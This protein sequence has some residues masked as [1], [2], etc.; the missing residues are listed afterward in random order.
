MKQ[1]VLFRVVMRR[2][3]VLKICLNHALTPDIVYSPKDDKTWLFAANDFSEGEISLQKFCLRFKTK[4][5][6]TEFKDAVD[7]AR[8]GT[9]E[10]PAKA[11]SGAFK[12]ASGDDVIFVDEIQATTEEKQKAKE[13]MLPENFFTYKTKKPC[14]GCRGCEADEESKPKTT[15]PP[16][17][18][19]VVTTAASTPVKTS[20]PSNFFSPAN[21]LYGT[22]A[23]FDKTADVSIFRTP[24]GAIG[25]NTK[26]AT[27]ASIGDI[28][29]TND[30]KN[31]E[32]SFIG[33]PHVFGGFE[34]PA[35]T[36]FGTPQNKQTSL[37]G[38][39]DA[40]TPTTT[41]TSLIAAPKLNALNV[42][43]DD[44]QAKD[45][46]TLFET[47]Q[48]NPVFG[49]ANPVFGGLSSGTSVNK[50]IFS[51]ASSGDKTE[52]SNKSEVTSIFG[53]DQKPVNL[54]S[55]GQGSLFGPGSLTNNQTKPVGSIFGT[56]SFG[57]SAQPQGF[58]AGKSVF[59]N[60]ETWTFGSAAEEKKAEAVKLEATNEPD[61]KT[62]TP[63]TND[64]GVKESPFK[65]DNT[66]SFAA[67]STAG[68]GF[69]V[70]GKLFLPRFILL[71][72]DYR[73]R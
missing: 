14:Q 31:K 52:D 49:K 60:S 71:S 46:K 18:V 65:V 39:G 47:A 63:K 67:L 41:K 72:L 37:F 3:Q 35:T 45:P 8:L 12:E 55:G 32:N 10:S 17:N 7:K 51:F 1:I 13:L 28:T 20:T 43:G 29:I 70:Q 73:T 44:N 68:T 30:A 5:I 54:F 16:V 27:P 22:P 24:L 25:S 19:P 62:T 6:A 59:G 64:D 48:N 2:E 53:G 33:K 4:E 56:N 15:A 57:S 26:S 50:S 21:S 58:G 38:T 69:N 34:K 36:L 66:L 11:L 40:Q 9:S 42:S 61:K 23:N